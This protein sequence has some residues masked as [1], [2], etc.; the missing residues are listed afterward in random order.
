MAVKGICQ[1]PALTKG[2]ELDI[3]LGTFST[4]NSSKQFSI[5]P[6]ISCSWDD[7]YIEN[8]YNYEANNSA[9]INAGKRILKKLNHF[10]IIPMAGLV[11][12]SFKGVTAEMQISVDYPKWDFFTDNQYSYEYTDPAKSFYSNWTVARYKLTNMFSIGLTEFFEW[13]PCGC[14]VFDKGITTSVTW[15]KWSIRFYAFNFEKEKREYWL[16]IR[17]NIKVKLKDK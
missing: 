6:L 13:Q 1:D 10:E 9:S 16:G 2:R 8:R 3:S 12:G 4:L 11:F 17:Y 7:Y 15:A 5:N 14:L